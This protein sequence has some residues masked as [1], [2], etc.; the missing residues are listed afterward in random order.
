MGVVCI[1][2]VPAWVYTASVDVPAKQFNN[3]QIS[4]YM[5]TFVN[6]TRAGCNSTCL[7]NGKNEKEYSWH[8]P[9]IKFIG[10][11]QLV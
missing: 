4:T 7:K 2:T 1:P 6:N 9:A 8:V 10:M 3:C 11:K 5:I